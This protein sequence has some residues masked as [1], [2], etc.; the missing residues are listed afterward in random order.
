MI[1]CKEV[2]ALI[3]SDLLASKSLIKRVEIR[4]HLMMCKH[5]SR[6]MKQLE[7]LHVA[8]GRIGGEIDHELDREAGKEMEA[9][10]LQKLSGK[11]DGPPRSQ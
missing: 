11:S 6:L 9:R 1:S 2:A 8:A 3:S 7:Q 5:C 10:I 4:L